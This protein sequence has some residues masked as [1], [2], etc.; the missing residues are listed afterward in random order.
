MAQVFQ[1][2][3]TQVIKIVEEFKVDY[4][5]AKKFHMIQR[6]NG[7]FELADFDIKPFIID[8][9]T[10]YNDDFQNINR[11]INSSLTATGRNGLILL[12]GKYGSGKTYYLRHLISNIERKFI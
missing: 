6:L 2:E 8:I 10:H 3:R 4:T 1:K 5:K 9:E 7:S 11:L 12:H